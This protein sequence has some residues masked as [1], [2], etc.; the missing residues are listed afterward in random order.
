MSTDKFRYA[1]Y[2]A[3]NDDVDSIL[4]EI[5][6][7]IDYGIHLTLN[8]TGCRGKD[9]IDDKRTTV[10]IETDSQF[11]DLDE[12]LQESFTEIWFEY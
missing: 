6:E 7:I 11:D 10:T 12:S 1:V 3:E 2:H 4:Q 9:P 5:P 8:A